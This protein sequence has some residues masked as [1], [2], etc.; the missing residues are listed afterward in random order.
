MRACNGLMLK[1]RVRF[2]RITNRRR[3]IVN[4]F[5]EMERAYRLDANDAFTALRQSVNRGEQ[6][7][8]KQSFYSV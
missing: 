4:I 6:L 7:L 5:G 8:C 3:K 2:V 1:A